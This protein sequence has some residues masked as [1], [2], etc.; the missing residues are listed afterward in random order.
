MARVRV[1]GLL[2]L[3]L[4][5]CSGAPI[6]PLDGGT[7]SDAGVTDAGVTD[8]G[9]TDAGGSDAGEVIDA[10]VTDGGSATDGGSTADGGSATDGGL[11]D[12]GAEPA[13]TKRTFTESDGGLLNPERGFYDVIDLTSTSTF[14]GVRNAGMTLALAGIRLDAFRT[15]PID[16][17]TLTAI[18]AGLVRARTAGIKI[19]LRFQYNDG[20]I[21]AADA[22][23]AQILAHLIQLKPILQNNSDV[24]AVMQGGF[25]G[26]WGEWHSS[27]NGLDNTT[28][29]RSVLQAILA[30]LPSS[31]T[32][33]VRTPNIV[34]AIF[35][36]GA[37]TPAQAFTGTDLARTGH[38]NDCF[39]A[40]V[41]D[42]EA[43]GAYRR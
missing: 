20:P 23:K 37:I 30:A 43:S 35:P 17:A 13:L 31:R 42:Y 18:E 15:T 10:G 39:L 22:S 8:A 3:L 5:G 38:H 24:I 2:V 29:Q 9:V 1:E 16:A 26:A 25:I 41:D 11:S 4:A 6:G 40:S 19:I 21:G 34:D 27:T 28:D 36:G 7:S 32:V 12:A 14:S 33:Q